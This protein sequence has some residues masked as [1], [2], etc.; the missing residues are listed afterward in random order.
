MTIT[1][2]EAEVLFEAMESRL[3]D[4]HTALPGLIGSYDPATQTAE[5]DLGVSRMIEGDDGKLVAEALPRLPNVRVG[6]PIGGGF[7][8]SLPMQKGDRVFVIF[9]EASIDQFRAKGTA[10]TP[11]DGR[12]FTLAGSFALPA[13]VTLAGTIPNA[14]ATDL[15]VGKIGGQQVRVKPGGTVEV[16][17]AVTGNADDYVAQAKKVRAENQIMYDALVGLGQTT[18]P[19]S[20]AAQAIAWINAIKIYLDNLGYPNSVASSNLKSDD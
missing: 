6:F 20:N 13:D 16:T 4:V 14:S 18:Y 5:I 17:D 10:G 3:I 7:F 8:I 1:P 9:S 19:V 2:E 12:R 11:G 15:V